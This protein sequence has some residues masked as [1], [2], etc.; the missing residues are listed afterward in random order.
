MSQLEVVY[1]LWRKF[2]EQGLE[3]LEITFDV[4]GLHLRATRAPISSKKMVNYVELDAYQPAVEPLTRLFD[5][6]I[7]DLEGVY[8]HDPNDGEE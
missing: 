4:D 6:A 2:N 5:R 8:S 1:D 7:K 3:R